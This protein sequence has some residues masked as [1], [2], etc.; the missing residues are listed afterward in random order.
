MSANDPAAFGAL[1]DPDLV[2]VVDEDIDVRN[3][4]DVEYDLATRMEASRD[5]FVVPDARGHEYIRVGK[6]GV[7]AKLGVDATIPFNEKSRFARCK[8]APEPIVRRLHDAALEAMHTATVRDRLESLGAQI[9]P[10]NEATPQY[11]GSFVKS[12]IEKWAAP[13]KASGVSVD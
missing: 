10:D 4:N 12:E 6:N 11:L 5:L 9:V 13:I 8:G 7:R 1:K 3:P 2:I